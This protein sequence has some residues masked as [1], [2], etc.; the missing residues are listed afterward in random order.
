MREIIEV[1]QIVQATD[2]FA[3]YQHKDGLSAELIPVW[4]LETIEEQGE[5]Y[6]MV[7]GMADAGGYLDEV[8][9]AV[10][11][12]GYCHKNGLSKLGITEDQIDWGITKENMRSL[13]PSEIG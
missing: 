13:D 8:D 12:V 7:C 9:D 11:F 5:T 1:K 2:W 10:N 6:P 4:A 3:I